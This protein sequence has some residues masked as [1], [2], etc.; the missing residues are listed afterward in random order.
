MCLCGWPSRYR[1]Y[2]SILA[3]TLV[4]VTFSWNS[5]RGQPVKWPEP[6]KDL[7][8]FPAEELHQN[9][10][11]GK[12][13]GGYVADPKQ[14]P[15]SFFAKLSAD[16][17]IQNCTATLIASESLITAAHCV[18]DGGTVVVHKQ[19]DSYNGRCE[20]VDHEY[21]AEL[22]ADWA[23]CIMNSDV[24]AE[25]YETISFRSDLI[26]KERGI[27]LAGYGCQPKNDK[28]QG[29]ESSPKFLVGDNRIAVSLGQARDP[30]DPNTVYPDFIVTF[31]AS[32]G[33]GAY[34]C[35]GDSGGAV[36]SIVP[37]FQRTIVAINSSFDKSGNGVSYLSALSAKTPMNFLQNWSNK[38]QK[39]CG[40]DANAQK[41]RL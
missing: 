30:Q 37:G 4:A 41:C 18:A 26:A 25:Q 10:T 21:P 1:P 38:K 6:S 27:M 35:D 28:P 2:R 8:F 12:V 20:H 17:R 29:P 33:S 31:A 24:P 22:S 36:F 19:N 23:M 15:A 34:L 16:S 3:G 7:E 39:L 40:V 11:E 9:S 13:A 14:W 5:A 32:S